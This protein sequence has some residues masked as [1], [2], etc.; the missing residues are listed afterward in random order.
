MCCVR[1]YYLV[2]NRAHFLSMSS[3]IEF[4]TGEFKHVSSLDFARV[5]RV[6]TQAIQVLQVVLS[7]SLAQSLSF[8]GE[9]SSRIRV[10][11]SSIWHE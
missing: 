10:S 1:K 7:S 6:L 3:F 9:N 4:Q 8:E 5:F 11:S 2:P